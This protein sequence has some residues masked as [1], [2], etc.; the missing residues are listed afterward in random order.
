MRSFTVRRFTAYDLTFSQ[1]HRALYGETHMIRFV[2]AHGAWGAGWFWKKRHPFMRQRGHQRGLNRGR[3]RLAHATMFGL[4]GYFCSRDTGR[5]FRVGEALL[6]GML[7]INT[8]LISAAEMS[9]EG[10]S[11]GRNLG[12][13]QSPIQSPIQSTSVADSV[14][15]SVDFSRRLQPQRCRAASGRRGPSHRRRPPGRAH[16]AAAHRRPCHGR[17]SAPRPNAAPPP[18]PARPH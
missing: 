8:G 18:H 16:D 4:A 12:R 15:N 9:F 3:S 11:R 14:A 10:A 13:R 17:D 5:V 2:I 1:S 7:G 6:Q